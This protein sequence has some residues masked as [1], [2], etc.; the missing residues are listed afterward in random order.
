MGQGRFLWNITES[1]SL[2]EVVLAGN[3]T[4]DGKGLVVEK[5][6]FQ[7]VLHL[8]PIKLEQG[9]E[10]ESGGQRQHTVFAM[11]CPKHKPIQHEITKIN[12]NQCSGSR[13]DPDSTGSVLWIW[14]TKES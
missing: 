6:P 10:V 8:A 4:V 13:L 14:V 11:D 12:K 2:P 9:W 5:P 3:S 1:A 7:R